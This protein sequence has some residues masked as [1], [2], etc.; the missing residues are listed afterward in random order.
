M[1]GD[2]WV[3][4]MVYA[5][6]ADAIPPDRLFPLDVARAYRKLDAIKPHIDVWWTTG[7]QS[8]QIL[9]DEE[10]GMAIMWDGRAYQLEQQG[11]RVQ[12]SHAGATVHREMFV[13][14]EQAPNAQRAFAFLE[15][16]ATHPEE[17]AKWVQEMRYGVANPRAFDLL[18]T[19]VAQTIATY[20]DNLKQSVRLDVAW[21]TANRAQ[22]LPRWSSW[23]GK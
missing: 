7:D 5:L 23:L 6:E 11:L 21:M 3:E 10:V 4:N 13:V 9:R 1:Y 15:W 8:Q 2:G 17:G 14:P 22:L 20:P 19:D 16:Y 12:I 18:P